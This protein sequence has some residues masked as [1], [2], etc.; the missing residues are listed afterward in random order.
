MRFPHR[1]VLQRELGQRHDEYDLR[2]Y[3]LLR[4]GQR[5]Y[6]HSLE[7]SVLYRD[8]LQFR[9]VCLFPRLSF[10]S[11]EVADVGT[12]EHAVR[13]ASRTNACPVNALLP[14]GFWSLNIKSPPGGDCHIFSCADIIPLARAPMS[15]ALSRSES[16]PVSLYFLCL[17]QGR[18]RGEVKKGAA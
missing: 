18:A 6:T 17:P 3:A 11:R 13:L 12:Q 14:W 8:P 1:Q 16:R 7:P 9:G 4:P 2:H 15:S 10:R 5:K